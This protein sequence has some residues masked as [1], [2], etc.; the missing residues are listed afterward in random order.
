MEEK[1]LITVTISLQIS[2]IGKIQMFSLSLRILR[3]INELGLF[4]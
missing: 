3:I 1:Q 4:L 2:S